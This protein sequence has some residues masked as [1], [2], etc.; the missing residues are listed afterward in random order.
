MQKPT[1]CRVCCL[2]F[3]LE[4]CFG[5]LFLH[6]VNSCCLPLLCGSRHIIVLSV[7]SPSW[8]AS[9]GRIIRFLDPVYGHR[10]WRLW[11]KHEKH[12]KLAI[13][14]QWSRSSIQTQLSQP[15][16]MIPF[17]LQHLT[18]AQPQPLVHRQLRFLCQA[19]LPLAH[20]LECCV[21][22]RDFPR[23]SWGWVISALRRWTQC[24][25]TIP[26]FSLFICVEYIN[27]HPHIFNPGFLIRCWL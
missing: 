17:F 8:H 24:W 12:Q 23:N 3:Q 14:V 16:K 2:R 5:S 13:N 9:D 20:G 15:Y 6:S 4:A 27:M 22:L 19:R 10:L 7:I 25:A 18:H 26:A 1:C 21:C 11:H